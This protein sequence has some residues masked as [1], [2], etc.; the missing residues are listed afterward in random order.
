MNRFLRTKSIVASAATAAVLIG[1]GATA[2]TAMAATG[3]DGAGVRSATA[4]RT[5]RAQT[6]DASCQ[7]IG[8]T[9]LHD[10][11]SGGV[12]LPAGPYKVSSPDFSCQT[13]SSYFTTFLN[14]N[15]G[16]IPGWTGQ[17]LGYGYGTYTNDTT[18]QYF[19]VKYVG[20]R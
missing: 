11:H 18:K 19:T 10:D 20:A 1:G 8:F 2:A 16:P 13:A 6:A 3:N 17:Q 4:A 7:G 9:V 14:K 12:V 5:T 15:Q